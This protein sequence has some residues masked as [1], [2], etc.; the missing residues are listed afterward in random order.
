MESL[1]DASNAETAVVE[2]VPLISNEALHSPVD[3]LEE[4]DATMEGD[5]VQASTSGPKVRACCQAVK[6]S[7]PLR[8]EKGQRQRHGDD[9]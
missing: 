8:A 5:D 3:A 9:A 1:E 2:A 6:R 7:S 4:A